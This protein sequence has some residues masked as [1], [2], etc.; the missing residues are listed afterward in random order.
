MTK[1]KKTVTTQP[2]VDLK[3]KS[4][5]KSLVPVI[6]AV[7]V[8]ALAVFTFY[9]YSNK[10]AAVVPTA[11]P[12][13]TTV[14]VSNPINLPKPALTSKTS[15]EA[16]LQSRRSRR[17]YLDKALSL[18][19]ISQMLW[20]AQG[21]TTTW[22]GRTAPSAKSAYPLTVYFAAYKVDD[23]NPGVYRYIPGDREPVHQIVQIKSGNL[24]KEVG[25]AIGQNA[26]QNSSVVFIIAG[27]MNAMAKAF[28]GKR[29]DNNVYLEAGHAAENMYLQAESL[30]L[31]MVTMAGFDGGKVA[32]AMGIPG[33]ETVIYAIP[34]GFP[35][36]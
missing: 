12:T 7:V 25:T 15:I 35:K 14:E 18:K 9:R 19:Q 32:A 21:V 27:D 13:P 16:A 17:D 29:V 24:Q 1:K 6:T 26:A 20:S 31:G 33:N 34:L 2:K 28:D 10:K 8:I 22:G 11:T 23:L 36:P 5:G 4:T 3:T 30:G